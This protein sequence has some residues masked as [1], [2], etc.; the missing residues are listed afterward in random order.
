MSFCI[1][2]VVFVARV[3]FSGRHSNF[4]SLL[5][6]TIRVRVRVRVRVT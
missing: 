1:V 6:H 4:M 5:C 3:Q 2:S